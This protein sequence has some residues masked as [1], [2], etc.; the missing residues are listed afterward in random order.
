MPIDY[1]RYKSLVESQSELSMSTQWMKELMEK[2]HGFP[3]YT[4]STTTMMGKS[5]GSR[6]ELKSVEDRPA[7]AGFYG[8]PAGY[9]EVV[10]DP[11]KPQTGSH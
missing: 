9:K 7:P 1:G 5:F 8:P 4:E 6:Q 2:I 3:V 10:F 11:M